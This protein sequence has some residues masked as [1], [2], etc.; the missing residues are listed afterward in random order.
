MSQCRL[1]KLLFRSDGAITVFAAIVMASLLLFFSFLIDYA[2]IAVFQKQAEDS[3]R[4]GVRSVLSAYDKQLFERYGLFGRGGTPP[5]QIFEQVFLKNNEAQSIGRQ[6]FKLINVKLE[7]FNISANQQLGQHAVFGRQVLEEMKYKAP[8]DFTIEVISK[9]VPLANSMKQSAAAVNSLN[10][11]RRLYEKREN[12]LQ[13]VLDLQEQAANAAASSD[14]ASLASGRHAQRQNSDDTISAIIDGYTPYFEQLQAQAQAVLEAQKQA[15]GDPDSEQQIVIPYLEETARYERLVHNVS[16][17]LNSSA[18]FIAGKHESLIQ[19]AAHELETAWQINE[20]MKAVRDEADSVLS[21][22]YEV[23]AQHEVAD[24][25]GAELDDESSLLMELRE[26]GEQLIKTD[27]WFEEYKAELLEQQDALRQ[28]S[29]AGLTF[30]AQAEAALARPVQLS[31]LSQLSQTSAALQKKMNIYS[32]LYD[33]PG[34]VIEER[35]KDEAEQNV[36]RQLRKNEE[37]ANSK[38]KQLKHLLDGLK[39]FQPSDEQKEQFKAAEESYRNN[40]RFNELTDQA[41]ENFSKDYGDAYDAVDHSTEVSGGMFSGLGDMLLNARDH[42]YYGE[43]AVHYYNA[44]QPQQL[45]AYLNSK[46]TS[47]LSEAA[48]FQQQELEYVLYGMH[49]PL[50]NI[51]AAY[52]EIVAVRLAVRLMEGLL[53]KRSLGHPLLILSAALIYAID[54]TVEDISSLINKGKAPL[55]KYAP[56]EFSYVDYIRLFMLLHGGKEQERL[57]RMI[58]VIEQSTG[59]TLAK[60]PSGITAEAVLSM[61][62]WFIPSLMKTILHVGS[63]HGRVA[64]KRYETSKTIGWSY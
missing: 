60:V 40:M 34:Q 13:R 8:I 7:Q 63:K 10:S 38:W 53:E 22:G 3:L 23:V 50:S 32:R 52:G 30:A 42:F 46:D 35:K 41:S 43:Y 6:S 45:A 31:S 48:D 62:L 21:A 17:A 25:Q 15:A 64:G 19:D 36:K 61:E 26:S 55:S 24:G 5:E 29:A 39:A 2:R 16:A 58:A 28:A 47:A 56:V 27:Q 44:F 11:L 33:A 49:K 37:E 18:G 51:A 54:R 20:Q 9:F 12:S 59:L 57:G 14:L 4:S 1:V